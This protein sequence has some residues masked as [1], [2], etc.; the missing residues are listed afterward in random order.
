VFGWIKIG[1]EKST[2]KEEDDP[3]TAT[4]KK[5]GTTART[6]RTRFRN[7]MSSGSGIQR[8]A[9]ADSGNADSDTD[10]N[11]DDK[12]PLS[13]PKPS[14]RAERKTKSSSRRRKI[15]KSDEGASETSSPSQVDAVAPQSGSITTRQRN[16]PAADPT[17]TPSMAALISPRTM[18]TVPQEYVCVC[19]GVSAS[20]PRGDRRC[21]CG[22]QIADL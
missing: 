3:A 4:L 17:L 13:S 8:D 10:S 2:K 18:Q 9:S 1:G 19:L 22:P 14:P 20:R 11:G 6:A 12:S 5:R 7:L 15:E 16:P 21:G